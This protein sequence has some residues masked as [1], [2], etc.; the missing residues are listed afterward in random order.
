METNPCLCI[1]IPEGCD[2]VIDRS[3]IIKALYH[4]NRIVIYSLKVISQQF[5]NYTWLITFKEDFDTEKLLG[6]QIQIDDT[7][8]ELEKV[9]DPNRFKLIGY[10]V[11]WLPHNYSQHKLCSFFS[12][13]GRKIERCEEEVMRIEDPDLP[14]DLKISTGNFIVKVLYDLELSTKPIET[15]IYTKDGVKFF[16]KRI[17]E[18]QTCL[19]CGKPG[20]I[21]RNCPL[22]NLRCENCGKNGH[23]T[24]KCS[25]A[26]RIRTEED[27]H[28]DEDDEIGE[29]MR[30][31]ES[32]TS[33]GSTNKRTLDQKSSPLSDE[34]PLSTVKYRK[35]VN[36]DEE[37]ENLT[38]DEIQRG[39]KQANKVKGNGIEHNLL[40]TKVPSQKKHTQEKAQ[41]TAKTSKHSK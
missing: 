34:S 14:D 8:F 17:G 7:N 40:G 23:S 25:M 31:I 41:N 33:N 20:H 28:P 10:K 11:L 19:K 15:S 22:N 32:K 21:R 18:A 5:N 36:T 26:L 3:K 30:E 29:K 1:K 9:I 12:G 2:V 39:L 4:L 13:N 24:E 16:V 35:T 27:H 38:I 37:S 6:R